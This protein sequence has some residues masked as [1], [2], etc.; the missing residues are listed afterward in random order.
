MARHGVRS[1]AMGWWEGVKNL[2]KDQELYC[3]VDGIAEAI[4]EVI[5]TTDSLM[6]RLSAIPPNLGKGGRAQEF[7]C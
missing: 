1:K 4:I 2:G 6:A 3:L 5:A 7:V